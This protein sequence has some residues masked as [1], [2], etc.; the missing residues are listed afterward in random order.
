MSHIIGN[1]NL[2]IRNVF[3]LHLVFHWTYNN[4]G[5]SGACSLSSALKINSTLTSFD[6]RVSFIKGAND[7]DFIHCFCEKRN[8]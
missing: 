3:Y 1:G 5:D 2:F 4:I 6:L 7:N 8:W